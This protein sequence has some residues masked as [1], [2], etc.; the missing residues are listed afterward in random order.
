MYSVNET[1]QIIKSFDCLP[2]EIIQN[3]I[4]ILYRLEYTGFDEFDAFLNLPDDEIKVISQKYDHFISIVVGDNRNTN[5]PY[6]NIYHEYNKK[7]AYVSEY[8]DILEINKY[9]NDL[10][11]ELTKKLKKHT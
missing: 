7:E 3:A 11:L 5:K 9:L 8:V 6:Y 2:N 10:I 1:T 4:A